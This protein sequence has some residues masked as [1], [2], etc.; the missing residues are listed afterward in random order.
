ME[1]AC[2]GCRNSL[3]YTP[4]KAKSSGAMR[5]VNQVNFQPPYGVFFLENRKQSNP[6]PLLHT[7]ELTA[8][9]AT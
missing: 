9:A 4:T 2:P 3:E 5:L 8:K 1:S 7:L 6:T